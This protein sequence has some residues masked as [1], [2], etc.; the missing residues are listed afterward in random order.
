M[1]N[2]KRIFTKALSGAL[3][4]VI[5]SSCLPANI[6]FANYQSQVKL[7][8][9]SSVPTT[10]NGYKI[11]IQWNNPVWSSYQDPDA[12]DQGDPDRPTKYR[13]QTNNAS[14]SNSSKFEIIE[15]VDNPQSGP[16]VTSATFVPSPPL[17]TGSIYEY[18]IVPYHFHTYKKG[19][20]T[21]QDY[22]PYDN[23]P[24]ETALFMSDITVSAK[25]S[26][27]SITVKWDNPVYRGQNVFSGYRIYY[28]S[29]G[30]TVKSFNNYKDVNIVDIANN[31]SSISNIVKSSDPTRNGVQMISCDI[32]DPSLLQG[33]VYA[34][35]VEPLLNGVL[36]REITDGAAF[37]TVSVG[38]N[39][40]KLAFKKMSEKE[41][42]TDD[43]H[44]D[45]PLEVYEDG[46]DFLKL[47]WWGISNTV[48][49]IDRIEIMEGDSI[50][51]IGSKIGTI[52]STRSLYINNWQIA[53]PSKVKYYQLQVYVVGK[54][55]PIGSAIA[56]F[57]PSLVEITPNKPDLYPK[58][59]DSSKNPILDIYWSAFVRYP[60]NDNEKAFVESDGTY[61][62]KNVLYDLWITDSLE[63]IYDESLSIK[64]LDREPATKLEIT[65][66]D[67]TAVPVLHAQSIKYVT[68]D[69][70]GN[71]VEKTPLDKNK[72]YYIKVVAIKHCSNNVDLVAEPVYGSIYYPTD[73]DISNPQALSKPPLRIKTDESG[74]KMITKESIT[75]EWNKNWFEI[76]DSATDS[77]YASTAVRNGNLVFGDNIN[78][79]D[80]LVELYTFRELDDIK[81]RLLENGY[82]D[83]TFSN[84]VFR[85]IDLSDSNIKYEL[86]CQPYSNISQSGGYESYVNNLLSSTTATWNA[87]TPSP[88]Y[89]G[90]LEYKVDKLTKNTPYVIIL[91]PYRILE[92][93]K[94]E[95]YPAYVTGTTLPDDTIIEITPTVPV[96]T[97]VSHN[98]IS[99]QVKWQEHIPNLSYELIVNETVLSDPSRG[100][101][102]ISFDEIAENGLEKSENERLFMYYTVTN[103]FPKTGYYVWV[104]SI[105]HNASEDAYSEWSNPIFIETD[106][107]EAP[108]PPSGL[109]LVGQN[110]L[111]MYNKENNVNYLRSSYEYL[112]V[113][114]LK[115]YYDTN[116][117]KPQNTGG[118][119]Y[120]VL[121]NEQIVNTY[122]VKYNKL[123]ANTSYYV[124]AK[125][126]LT[127]SQSKSTKDMGSVKTYSYTVQL[128]PNA[129]FKDMVEVVLPEDIDQ[130]TDTSSKVYVVESEWSEVVRLY[131]NLSEGE[132]DG[133]VNPDLYPLPTDDFEVIFDYSTNSLTYRF[134]SNQIDQDGKADNLVDQRL[135]SKLVK[136]K[137]FTYPIDLTSYMSMSIRTRVVEIP[138]S[139]ISAFDEKKINLE[140]KA[141]NACITFTPG[142]IKTAEVQKLAGY[143]YDGTTVKI[144][145]N[146]KPSDSPKLNYNQSYMSAPQNVGVTV[147][148]KY[149]V[150]VLDNAAKEIKVDLKTSDRAAALDSNVGTYYD[151]KATDSWQRINA[152]YDNASG[153][154]S[155]NTAKLATFTVIANKAPI[156][157]GDTSVI[158][159]N[160]T[161]VASK[162]NVTDMASFNPQKA[163]S[164]VQFNNMVAAVANNKK[165]V[166]LNGSLS[167][168]DFNALSKKGILLSGSVVSREQAVNSLVK[169][170]E[171]KT[172]RA[173]V[174]YTPISAAQYPDIK[175]AATAYQTSM[176]KAGDLGFFESSNSLLA[177][178]KD[179]LSLNEL[180]YMTN[181]ILEDCNY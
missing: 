12:V 92:N 36:A 27:N 99:F 13:I 95:A 122:I 60:Y 106:D 102:Y 89:N 30:S 58:V 104:R 50:T 170:Y 101:I 41:Y 107:L 76:Y 116:N 51:D 65:H 35:K 165:D 2:L 125:T 115:D 138:Y 181:I 28:Q 37:K 46:K 1:K 129:D 117:E 142:F 90:Y 86:L 100:E 82:S 55:T 7:T 18:Q 171:A 49:T 156:V 59:A 38:K 176:L 70:N 134:R 10:E 40:F 148:T 54:A 43:A 71:Y 23:T 3:A 52:F 63:S 103:L 75:V 93:G 32:Y 166:S 121:A 80:E 39:I 112:V 147:S 131:T 9:I 17:T 161:N 19:D 136:N 15:N 145:I 14:I 108:N 66:I 72:T 143:G 152:K 56:S 164:V 150:V 74:T 62:D 26:G 84:V 73:S 172:G 139:V 167:T 158:N 123:L 33:N 169:L 137:V 29:G 180:F 91:R 5:F 178:P 20:T 133:S 47:H 162:I 132:Y 88:N 163:V 53:K 151:T 94:K 97:E 173:I 25:G 105:A 4:G 57:D 22:A 34:V 110:N 68:K 120:E 6:V 81:S 69:I 153:N 126:K 8:N 168:N 160:V 77:W 44:I 155:F 67:D 118:D 64:I 179:I 98:D 96:L 114:W 146:E 109:G 45:I 149:N 159:S 141:N 177:R 11:N 128:S 127:V 140:V 21:Y 119:N 85:E 83:K 135:I 111:N 78:S 61:V 130:S 175:N 154:Y 79:S 157:A 87:I 16:D 113:E 144:L 48:G 24:I 174:N 31:S 124:R 42:R